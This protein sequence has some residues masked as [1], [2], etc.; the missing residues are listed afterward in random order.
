LENLTEWLEVPFI[1]A[2][3]SNLIKEG[4]SILI[5]TV[6]PS[7]DPSCIGKIIEL[8]KTERRSQIFRMVIVVDHTVDQDDIYMVAWQILGN[9]DPVRDHFMISRDT[10]LLDGTIKFYRSGGFPRRWPEIVCSDTKTIEKIDKKWELLGLGEFISSPSLK[11]IR[12]VRSDTDE[13]MR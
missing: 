12:L 3:N 7:E 9:T 10:L 13:I 2:R 5:L 4:I 11:N 6:N 1:K 8:L